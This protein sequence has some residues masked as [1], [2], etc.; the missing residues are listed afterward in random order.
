MKFTFQSEIKSG[1]PDALFVDAS[2]G[3]EEIY[4]RFANGISAESFCLSEFGNERVL[5]KDEEERLYWEKIRKDRTDKFTKTC[6]KQRGR[7]KLL[8]KAEK[9]LGKHLIFNDSD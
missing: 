8:K 2:V 5:L 9:E 3:S 4:I 7:D 6:K 1:F